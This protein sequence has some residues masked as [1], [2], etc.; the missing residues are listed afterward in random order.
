MIIAKR[1]LLRNT[2]NAIIERKKVLIERK[3][4]E[5]QENFVYQRAK[6]VQIALIFGKFLH[7]REMELECEGMCTVLVQLD[8]QKQHLDTSNPRMIK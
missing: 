8:L 3:T 5:H 6:C 4:L 2:Q 7:K 1:K